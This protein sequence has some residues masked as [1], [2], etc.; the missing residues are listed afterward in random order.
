MGESGVIDGR[1]VKSGK[2]QIVKG[3]ATQCRALAQMRGVNV[4]DLKGDIRLNAAEIQ[5][6][7]YGKGD[8]GV[9]MACN[10]GLME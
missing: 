10:G 9:Y 4:R 7:N 3:S 6:L 1:K 2:H 5:K 8:G